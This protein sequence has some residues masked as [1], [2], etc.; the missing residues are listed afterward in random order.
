MLPICTLRQF[1][2]AACISSSSFPRPPGVSPTQKT[3]GPPDSAAAGSRGSLATHDE[4]LQGIR[5]VI[6]KCAELHNRVL[7]FAECDPPSF[8][9]QAF[10]ATLHPPSLS[11]A[12]S[13]AEWI[14][15]GSLKF[16]FKP[17]FPTDGD[18]VQDALSAGQGEN[19]TRKLS[20]LSIKVPRGVNMT[21]ISA[22]GPP[23]FLPI[24]QIH[25]GVQ[26]H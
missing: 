9:Y 11:A 14:K 23:N 16:G 1:Y 4:N 6:K 12:L 25:C 15:Y 7:F 5:L 24:C 2:I 26:H 20:K 21:P 18:N 10:S 19:I 17:R 8:N 22:R 3:P 13:S